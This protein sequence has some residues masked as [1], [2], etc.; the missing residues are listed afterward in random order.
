MSCT[1]A[2]SPWL[3]GCGTPY[4]PHGFGGCVDMCHGTSNKLFPQTE[5]RHACGRASFCLGSDCSPVAR[6]SSG[7]CRG[8]CH[9]VPASGVGAINWLI[10]TGTH[11]RQNPVT[12][13]EPPIHQAGSGVDMCFGVVCFADVRPNILYGRVCIQTEIY[14]RVLYNLYWRYAS[15]RTFSTRT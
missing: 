4:I 14:C 8:L 1:K 5:W 11:F 3:Q 13:G 6:G 9:R 7:Q 10:H 12:F 15:L 2:K